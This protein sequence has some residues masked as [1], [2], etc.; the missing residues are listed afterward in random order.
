MYAN[1][2]DS[3]EVIDL[4][5]I[6][7]DDLSKLE[8]MIEEVTKVLRESDTNALWLTYLEMVDTLNN[9]LMAER[10][11]NWDLY[12]SSLRSMLPFFAGSG[13]SNYTKSLFWFLQEMD[14]LNPDV[15][16]EF[17]KGLFVIR[18][19]NTFWSGISPDLCIIN[20]KP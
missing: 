20:G 15:L 14:E 3:N 5:T 9:N 18:R 17:K 11:S 16:S 7:S 6:L 8:L 1:L 2:I 19:S 13:R 10:C 4:S 12:L